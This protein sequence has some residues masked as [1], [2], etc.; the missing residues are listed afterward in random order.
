MRV[1]TINRDDPPPSPQMRGK[2]KEW[3]HRML[4][5][6]SPEDKQA[7]SGRRQGCGTEQLGKPLQD[8]K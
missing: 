4:S 5:P 8:K 2:D 3:M 1:R 6:E 7:G